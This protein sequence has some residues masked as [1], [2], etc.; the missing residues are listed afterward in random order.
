MNF[1]LVQESFVGMLYCITIVFFL[2][3]LL[4]KVLFSCG[5]AFLKPLWKSTIQNPNILGAE[6]P[7]SPREAS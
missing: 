5:K 3:Y 7:E 2:R 1:I 6:I 4:F